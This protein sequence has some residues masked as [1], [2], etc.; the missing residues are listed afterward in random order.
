M[1]AKSGEHA[2]RT[3]VLGRMA[4]HLVPLLVLL[5]LAAA[6][7]VMPL[8]RGEVPFFLDIED[9]WYPFRLHAWRAR[10]Q[11][12]LPHWIPNLFCGAPFVGQAEAALLYP[13][14]LALDAIHPAY[15]LVPHLVGHRFLLGGL[16]YVALVLRGTGRLP[17][18]LGG[19]V[20]LLSGFTNMAV[21]QPAHLRA[22]AWVP[23]LLLGAWLICERRRL[24]GA[25]VLGV[26]AALGY[27]AGYPAFVARAGLALPILL[28]ADPRW[29]T[30]WPDWR[31]RLARFG[32]AGA[33]LVLAAILSAGQIVATLHATSISQRALGLHP[34][35]ADGFRAAPRDL[36]MILLPRFDAD[37]GVVRAGFAYVGVV[38][39]ALALLAVLRRT[40]GSAGFGA[41]ALFALVAALGSATPLGAAL[42][43]LPLM[44][45]FRN[46][47]QM[48]I[49]L[50]FALAVLAALGLREFL[51]RA[52]K[53]REAALCVGAPLLAVGA[54]F[55]FPDV[56]ADPRVLL[57]ALLAVAGLAAV[58]GAWIV[59]QRGRCPLVASLALVAFAIVDAGSLGFT[60]PTRKGRVRKIASVMGEPDAGLTRIAQHHG[61]LGLAYPARVITS[62]RHFNWDNH[63]V[64]AG[65]E[66]A[67]G[68][69]SLTPLRVMDVGR[70]I[71]EGQPF[72]RVPAAT[73]LY[74][75]GP[76]RALDSPALDLLAIRYA[77]GFADPPG[78]LWRRIGPEEWER[79]AVAPARLVADVQTVETPEDAARA[80]AQP[81]FAAGT[82]VVVE[83]PDVENAMKSAGTSQ[84]VAVAWLTADT[85]E[86]QYEAS[87]PG[88]LLWTV[89]HD[90]GWRAWIDGVETTPYRANYAFLALRVPAGRHR[91]AWRY[92]TPGWSTG[93]VI[94]GIGLV[95]TAFL[96][97]LAFRRS[98]RSR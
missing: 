82:S 30:S 52:P 34:D 46:P 56:P 93:L 2:P 20:A 11:G 62:D 77:A 13:A 86:M 8:F 38:P 25:L 29:P 53:A 44:G 55:L 59:R 87:A 90:P 84:D 91:V 74:D 68:L 23:A 78:P 28:I 18:L 35:F 10:A 71:E 63:V 50:C 64:A 97:W 85:A 75:F 48:L 37:G 66:N 73:P 31:E 60:Y 36:L 3:A 45:Y 67:R 79:D 58:A 94:S 54:A 4:P 9:H 96:A 14:H 27:L 72:E 17:A 32:T 6:P 5:A 89:T 1:T 83:V 47:S 98:R 88:L 70:I 7:F 21:Q 15:T 33:A 57:R 19:A 42:Q 40:R 41:A 39:V 76:L 49:V 80:L 51:E 65:V 69:L 92:R 22:L 12:A 95:A 43:K 61:R 26:G 81:G 24:A 16:L